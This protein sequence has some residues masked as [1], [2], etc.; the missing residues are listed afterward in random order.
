MNLCI[1]VTEDNGLRTQVSAHFGSAPLF[2]ILNTDSGACRALPNKNLHHG[3]GMCQPLMSLAGEQLDGIAV[4]GI[5]MGALNKLQAANV[6]VFISGESTVEETVAA[7]KSGSLREATPAMACGHHG[8]GPRGHGHARSWSPRQ[9]P[10]AAMTPQRFLIP[11][12]LGTVCSSGCRRSEN[13]APSRADVTASVAETP[14]AVGAHD[15]THPPI[16]CPLRKQGIDPTRSMRPFE[17]VGKYIA[18]LERAIGPRGRS[19]TRL[20]RRS[21]SRAWRPCLIWARARATS[22]SGFQGV[23]V[24]QGHRGGHRG[25]G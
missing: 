7:F 24:R 13:A 5:G 1:P 16:D 4:G 11:V 18:F 10:R 6:R 25:R 19:P 2:L 21:A 15:P 3:H 9:L 23:A 12:L 17:D 22:A 8:H 20:S 14:T